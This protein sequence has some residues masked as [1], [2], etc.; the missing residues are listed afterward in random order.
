MGEEA[1][2]KG[3]NDVE[4]KIK[5]QAETSKKNMLWGKPANDILN[6]RDNSSSVKP[7]RAIWEMVQNARDTSTN[8]SNIIFT[9]KE[10]LFEFKHD[11]MPFNNDTLNALILQT[12]AK[13]R[14]DGDQVGQY[15]TGFLTTHKFGREF[16]LAGSLK[17]VENEELYYNFP[18][19]TINRKPNTREEMIESLANQFKEKENWLDKYDYRSDKPEKWTVFKYFQPNEIERQNVELAF[20]QAQEIVPYVLCLNENI[21]SIKFCDEVKNRTISFYRKEKKRQ[22]ESSMSYAY[23]TTILVDD[24]RNEKSR[25][26]SILK[27]ESKKTVTTKKGINKSMVT[28][29]PPIDNNIVSNLSDNISKLFIYLPLVGTERWGINFVIHAPMF[30]CS[31]DDRSSLRL[32]IDGQTEH[33][34]AIENCKYIQEA[35]DILFDYISQHLSEWQDVHYLAPIDFDVSNPNKELSDYYKELKDLWLQKMSGLGIVSVKTV[36][37]IIRKKPSCIYVLDSA[38][39]KA[40]KE[41]EGLLMPI[42]NVLLNMHHDLI[43]IPEHL[44]FWSEIFASWYEGTDCDQ[45]IS[46]SNII[47]YIANNGMAVVNEKDLLQICEYL[48]DS[49]Q[50]S[51]FDKNILLAE[52]GTLT[53]KSEGYKNDI[54]SNKLKICIKTL[55]PE[56]TS[57][58]VKNEFADLIKLPSF[59]DKNVKE[60][61]SS[62][63]EEMQTKIKV[64]TDVAKSEWESSRRVPETTAGLLNEG[65]RNALMDYCYMTIPKNS[66]SF[67][68]KALEIIREYYNYTFDFTDKID[69]DFF[70]WR[71][72]IRTLLCHTLTEF[73]ILNDEKKKEQTDW[74]KRMIDCVYAFSDFKGMLQNYRVYLS[75]SEEFSYCNELKRDP[76]IPEKMKDIYNTITSTQGNT[77]EIRKELFKHE[78]GKIAPTDATCEIVVFGKEIMD[79]ISKSGKYLNE[80]DSYEHK[81]LIMDIINNFDDETE[82]EKWKSA[83]ESIYKDIPSLLAKLVLNKDDRESMIKIMKIKDKT[84]LNKAAEIINDENLIGIWEMGQVAWMEK[85]NQQ[86]DFDKKKELGKYVENYL[87]EELKDILSDNTVEA[88]VDDVQGGQDIIVSINDE[89]IYYIEVKSRWVVADSVMM[90]ATQLDRS[91]EKK[92][93]YALFVVD[94]IGFNGENVKEHIYPKTM[95][96]FVSRIRIVP[97]IG[98]LNKEIIP[99]KRNSNEQVHI[100][101][102]YKSIVPQRLISKEGIDYNSFLLDI[103]KP[104]VLKTL[105]NRQL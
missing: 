57:K 84:R 22:E 53:N 77:I 42:Y 101:G 75:Q 25:E 12:S 86:H 28:V 76:G 54:S 73:T 83:F 1:K 13:S 47:D 7:I 95:D 40:I 3:N 2:E 11:G 34:P 27:L 104:K 44:I 26:F 38:L 81:D 5:K 29:I 87:R 52:D 23:F 58:F 72:A 82:G 45:I 24:S 96:E 10:G 51:F 92:D 31:S 6:G 102:D 55:L 100:G 18:K 46:I 61:L 94:M 64:V 91:V 59:N 49:D 21:K 103:L 78:F 80:I 85:Q 9:R 105:Q 90:S 14:N 69:A 15:G 30:T 8:Q 32:I 97:N 89:P 56:Q 88:K 16:E 63:T 50:L 74:I 66:T 65:Q 62:C 48:R 20:Y 35:S 68:F 37:G 19:L 79:E 99:T 39:T 67:Q 71:G 43:P 41:K 33:D 17:L 4:Y 93:C 70:E 98:E 36:D 60:A